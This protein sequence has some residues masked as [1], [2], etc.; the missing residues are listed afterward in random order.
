MFLSLG[1]WLVDLGH[2][3]WHI[4]HI[5]WCL[6]NFNVVFYHS[7]WSFSLPMTRWAWSP[8]RTTVRWVTVIER[9]VC[10]CWQFL[11]VSTLYNHLYSVVLVLSLFASSAVSYSNPL[12]SVPYRWCKSKECSAPLSWLRITSHPS[13]EPQSRKW[14]CETTE[15]SISEMLS[16]WWVLC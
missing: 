1:S 13:P 14:R 5:W 10:Y 8:W 6:T 7:W 12:C 3:Y 15:W 16:C 11:N 9:R 4:K 2:S